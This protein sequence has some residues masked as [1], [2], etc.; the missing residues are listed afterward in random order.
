M[1]DANDAGD[2][3]KRVNPKRTADQTFAIVTA[4]YHQ[5][6]ELT[7]LIDELDVDDAHAVIHALAALLNGTILNAEA[8]A[9]MARGSAV[10]RI[11]AIVRE[12]MPWLFP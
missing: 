1:H 5:M 2:D 7:G 6:P 8:L 3:A 11:F 9:G 4:S 12:R 10:P